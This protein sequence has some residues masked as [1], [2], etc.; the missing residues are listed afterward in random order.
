RVRVNKA[1][2]RCR[3]HKIKCSGRYPCLNCQKHDL[4][5]RYRALIP[6][7]SAPRAEEEGS[8]P[9]KRA[10]CSE[11]SVHA[12][13][14]AYV[15][16]LEH[17]VRH[18][19]AVVSKGA[20]HGPCVDNT[21]LPYKLDDIV[22]I[23]RPTSS[24]WRLCRRYQAALAIELCSSLYNGLSP[25][26]QAQVHI[27]RT[28]YFGFNMSGCHYLR[29][30]ALPPFPDP[31]ELSSEHREVLI[32]FF[33]KE[34]NPLYAIVHESVFREQY[35]AFRDVLPEERPTNNVALFAAMLSLILAL[36]IRFMEF[37]KPAG[38]ARAQLLV[39]ETLYKYAHLVLLIFS[40]EWESFEL[41]QCWLLSTL[42]L[43][44]SHRQT[45]C[46]LSFGHALNMC[47]SMGLGK[48]DQI[49]HD[50]S[51]YEV[52]KAKRIF[53]AVY[54]F[55]RIIGLQG[56]RISG[57]CE[58][59]IKRMFPLLD[60]EKES[61]NDDW[62]TVPAFAMLHIARLAH[63]L[64]LAYSNNHDLITAEKMTREFD[65]VREWLDTNGFDDEE[66][67]YG[68]DA[69]NAEASSLIK[70]QVKLH[71][72]ELIQCIHAK[73][74]FGIFGHRVSIE[75]M[76]ISTIL[77]CNKDIIYLLKKVLDSGGLYAPWYLTLQ[78]ILTV[79]VNSLVFV[80]GGIHVAES[81]RLIKDTMAVL[82]VIRD[83]PVYD[84]NGELIFKLRFRM[85]EE[86][87]WLFKMMNHIMSLHYQES[88]KG[89]RELGTDHGS[90]AVN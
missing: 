80:N 76:K 79:G 84:E 55:D 89:I 22:V 72:Y 18:L 1:C 74:L 86:C 78:L 66:D 5:C 2:E 44:I 29:P 37:M 62:I 39:E 43:R 13:D 27:P 8:S 9:A 64:N 61:A 57:M 85:V 19:E 16:Y 69:P 36:G 24:K 12:S 70:A 75:G 33:F 47:R 56:G 63:Y 87:R 53:Y 21:G 45:S 52:A 25:E 60:F 82:Q 68:P 10:H 46:H 67:I 30:D 34:I 41:I 31:A 49:P 48:Y 6:V 88:L 81:R 15:R 90:S 32:D 35:K 40:A 26:A 58:D 11:P 23:Q 20:F 51:A 7:E 77:Q 17:K 59:E 65:E 54:S 3:L 4:A 14:A 73:M 71:F 42:Y 38:P 28:N 83:S 50:S